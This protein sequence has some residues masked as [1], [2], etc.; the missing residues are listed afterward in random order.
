[1]T[2]ESRQ[3]EPLCFGTSPRR[4]FGVW[5]APQGHATG[6]GVVLCNPFGQEAVRAHRMWRVLA[7]RLARAGH[8]V[9]RFDYHGTG[10]AMGDD[11]DFAL[12][13]AAQDLDE[14]HRLL[15]A[16]SGVDRIVWIGMRLGATIALQRAMRPC[17]GLIRLVLWD[18]VFDGPGYLAYLRQRHVASLEKAFSVLPRPSPSQLARDPQRYTDEAI[19]YALSAALR[20]QLAAI[21]PDAVQWPAPLPRGTYVLADPGDAAVTAAVGQADATAGVAW[22]GLRHGTDWTAETAENSSLVPTAALLQLTQ[23]VGD[24]A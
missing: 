17:P 22:A 1:M 13:L 9:L 16:R 15:M 19:G 21:R 8:A 24:A 6:L 20:H 4:L 5:H 3:I 2:T 14:A 18:P 7:E 10:D 12:D 23:L 11:L